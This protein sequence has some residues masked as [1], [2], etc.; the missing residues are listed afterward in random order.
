[1][2]SQL[3]V[4]EIQNTYPNLLHVNGW[5]YALASSLKCIAVANAVFFVLHLFAPET[6]F[7]WRTA[8]WLLSYPLAFI[9]GNLCL[10][11]LLMVWFYKCAERVSGHTNGDFILLRGGLI[12]L[13]WTFIERESITHIYITKNFVEKAFGLASISIYTTGSPK[14]TVRVRAVDETS[15]ERLMMTLNIAITDSRGPNN[16]QLAKS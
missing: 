1:M 12:S 3:S 13:H 6:S 16:E 5:V 4:S 10:T 9:C 7:A 14:E 15:L 11:V 2:K 8:H